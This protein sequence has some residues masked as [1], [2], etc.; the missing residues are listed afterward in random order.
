[1]NFTVF[2]NL[3]ICIAQIPS[4]ANLCIVNE[5]FMNFEWSVPPNNISPP[6]SISSTAFLQTKIDIYK[7]L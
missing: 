4:V 5:S 1:M 3:S 2:T 7:I 6:L